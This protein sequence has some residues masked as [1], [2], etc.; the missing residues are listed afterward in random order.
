MMQ[1]GKRRY[2]EL[3]FVAG[4]ATALPFADDAFDV[5]TISYGLRNVNDTLAALR[6]M[7]RVT[8]PGGRIVIAEFSTPT[9]PVVRESY[10]WFLGHV[11]PPA[12]RVFSS[13]V[14][15][16]D[17]LAESIL[18]WPNQEELAQLLLEAGWRQVA[19]KNL[20]GGIVALH[21]AVKPSA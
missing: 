13:N 7:Y 9:T 2:P 4:D 3:Q 10:K 11:M 8:K 18:S 15:S 19:Y 6:Q 16:Y 5:V 14:E 21:Q 20:S 1:E 12:A 17:Y